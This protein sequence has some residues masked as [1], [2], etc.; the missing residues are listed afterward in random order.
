[1]PIEKII[2]LEDN[3]IIQKNLERQLR[4]RQHDVASV[5]TLAAAREYLSK[6]NWD[7]MLLDTRLPDGKGID[8]LRDLNER[9]QKPLVVV[10][11]GFGSVE[12]VSEWM[13]E[14]AFDYLIKPFCSEQID[15][16]LKKAETFGRI[17]GASHYLM[18]KQ[19]AMDPELHGRSSSHESDD[20]KTKYNK[21]DEGNL[22][23][24]DELEKRHIFSALK[25]CNNNR[26]HAAKILD[27]SIRTLR[28]KMKEYNGK[29][30]ASEGVDA[31]A[32]SQGA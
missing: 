1:M 26:T 6:D 23:T 20:D 18:N 7:L 32:K 31:A 2:V 13:D 27:I 24:L 30:K 4:K 25:H 15:A 16:V 22:I 11:S 14:G 8:L 17:V 5:E 29:P 12:S 28:N 21:D 3:L 9:P 10:M 19:E